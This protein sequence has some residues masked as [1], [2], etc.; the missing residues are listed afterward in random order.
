M[1]DISK[2]LRLLIKQANQRIVRIE[3]QYGKDKWAVKNLKANLDNKMLDAWTEKGRVRIPKNA[4]ADDIEK[5]QNI[6]QKFVD[7]KTSSI[8]SLKFRES[9]IKNTIKEKA[10]RSDINLDAEDIEVLYRA[11]IDDDIKWAMEETRLG[12]DFWVFLAEG[13]KKHETKEHFI[14]RI[15]EYITN[16]NEVDVRRRLERIYEEYVAV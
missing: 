6:T 16:T 12:S 11:M 8:R 14:E 1:A 7:A 9:E 13:R 2:D 5:I 15:S 3:K 10:G 4:T